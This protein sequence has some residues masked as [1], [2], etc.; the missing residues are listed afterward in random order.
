MAYAAG[1]Q[2]DHHLAAVRRFDFD[3]FHHHRH[4]V[5]AAYDCFCLASH[6]DSPISNCDGKHYA[7]WRANSP[8]R[9]AHAYSR[10][11]FLTGSPQTAR[12]LE[13]HPGCRRPG[14]FQVDK[15]ETG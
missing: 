3:L 2:L 4:I 6:V 14:G 11:A 13:R 8:N 5:L 10:L 9:S 12:T 1:A 7:T 15:G